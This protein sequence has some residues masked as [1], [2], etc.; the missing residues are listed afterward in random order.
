MPDIVFLAGANPV[1]EARSPA[2]GAALPQALKGL[3]TAAG[4]I[5]TFS[6]AEKVELALE[7]KPPEFVDEPAIPSASDISLAAEP[8]QGRPFVVVVEV[9][10]VALEAASQA[11]DEGRSPVQFVGVEPPPPVIPDPDLSP[12]G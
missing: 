4:A 6:P 7:P 2:A 1:S 10:V 12:F 8:A 3:A 9:P 11:A 5:L